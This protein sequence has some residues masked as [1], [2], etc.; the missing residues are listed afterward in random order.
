M[1]NFHVKFMK[2]PGVTGTPTDDLFEYQEVEYPQLSDEHDVSVFIFDNNIFKS[3]SF[4]LTSSLCF[5]LLQNFF[6]SVR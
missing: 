4:Y 2:R 6:G 1:R 5:Q 3:I